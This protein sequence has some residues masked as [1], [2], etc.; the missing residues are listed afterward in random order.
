MDKGSNHVQP[1]VGSVG[2]GH[3]WELSWW[4]QAGNFATSNSSLDEKP[5]NRSLVSLSLSDSLWINGP[6]DD[7]RLVM[8]PNRFDLVRDTPKPLFQLQ[9][10]QCWLARIDRRT[11]KTKTHLLE[12]SKRRALLLFRRRVEMK[13]ANVRS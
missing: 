7:T 3:C 9:P 13:V 1:I 6:F 8:R 2:K 4:V 10:I 11:V 12:Q 5:F